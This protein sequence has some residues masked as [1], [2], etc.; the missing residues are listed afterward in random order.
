VT[1]APTCAAGTAPAPTAAD[2]ALASWRAAR[3]GVVLS[4]QTLP[5]GR[6]YWRAAAVADDLLTAARDLALLAPVPE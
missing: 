6:G 4:W 1:G 2:S 5:D 3:P